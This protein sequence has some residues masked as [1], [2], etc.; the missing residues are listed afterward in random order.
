[1]AQQLAETVISHS[2][3]TL[4]KTDSLRTSLPRITAYVENNKATF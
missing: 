1:M 2:Y 4:I 3:E